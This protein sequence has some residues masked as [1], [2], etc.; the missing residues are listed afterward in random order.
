MLNTINPQIVQKATSGLRIKLK[1]SLDFGFQNQ[2]KTAFN[3]VRNAA[4]NEM[5][6]IS[7]DVL[8]FQ[9]VGLNEVA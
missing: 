4:S 3:S 6:K 7:F 2:R 9:L 1:S 8:S 5:A